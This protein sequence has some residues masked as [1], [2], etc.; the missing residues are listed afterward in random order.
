MQIAR[1]ECCMEGGKA[2]KPTP[3]DSICERGVGHFT[4]WLT[5][6]YRVAARGKSR[7]RLLIREY[8]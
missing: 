1:D 3:V 6:G 8:G 2:T 4:D 7:A 5:M